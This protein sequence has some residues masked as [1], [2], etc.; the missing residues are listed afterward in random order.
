MIWAEG[1]GLA[2]GATVVCWS[3]PDLSLGEVLLEARL[4]QVHLLESLLLRVDL[5]DLGDEH[6]LRGSDLQVAHFLVRLLLDLAPVPGIGCE[7]H[8]R[9]L[10]QRW[11][12]QGAAVQNSAR[13]G[14]M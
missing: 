4:G 14:K 7:L 12:A 10:T 6:L 3:A 5:G 13:G 2:C 9:F 1:P 8:F 11:H